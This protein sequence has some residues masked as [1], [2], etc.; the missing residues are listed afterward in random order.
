MTSPRSKNTAISDDQLEDVTLFLVGPIKNIEAELLAKSIKKENKDLN[1]LGHTYKIQ[2]KKIVENLRQISR[3][4]LSEVTI[5]HVKPVTSK[6]K[7]FDDYQYYCNTMENISAIVQREIVLLDS[8]NALICVE[9]WIWILK[10]C[11]EQHD[12]FSA[13]SILTGLVSSAVSFTHLL[14]KISPLSHRVFTYYN[15]LYCNQRAIHTIQVKQFN[16]NKAVIP[17][18]SALPNLLENLKTSDDIFYIKG[19]STESLNLYEAMQASSVN[20]QGNFEKMLLSN[21]NSHYHLMKLNPNESLLDTYYA[22]GKRIHS[23]LKKK[24]SYKNKYFM[25]H[26]ALYNEQDSFYS[27]L[28]T[29]ATLTKKLE[30]LSFS[31]LDESNKKILDKIQII[32]SNK[33]STYDEKIKKMHFLMVTHEKTIDHHLMKT[34]QKIKQTLI[35]LQEIENGR[36]NQEEAIQQ[37]RYA[38]DTYFKNKRDRGFFNPPKNIVK[39]DGKADEKATELLADRRNVVVVQKL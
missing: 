14:E 9:R 37:N 21:K 38:A 20:A 25:K 29:L 7:M 8:S 26:I 22:N 23:Q 18:L 11:H 6:A 17:L 3:L 27:H 19:Q 24:S 28:Y 30:D 12:H 31:K 2:L 5:E 4:C 13:A 35:L 1:I 15:D 32:A 34:Y 39:D 33:N 16:N 36:L 10:I